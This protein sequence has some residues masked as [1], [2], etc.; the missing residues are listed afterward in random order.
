MHPTDSELIILTKAYLWKGVHTSAFLAVVLPFPLI[1]SAPRV[2]V[3]PQPLF[4]LALPL[5]IVH[6]PILV[7]VVLG[8]GALTCGAQ[9]VASSKH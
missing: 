7:P 2:Q 4:V 6:P 9:Q 1:L 5:T 3:R 8:I